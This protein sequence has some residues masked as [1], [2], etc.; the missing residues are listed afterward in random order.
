MSFNKESTLMGGTIITR[1]IVITHHNVLSFRVIYYHD[2]A[3]EH[4]LKNT[5]C[6]H[7]KM[8]E[9]WHQKIGPIHSCRMLAKFP[10]LNSFTAGTVFKRHIVR[11]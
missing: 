3:G 6:I 4:L 1:E 7:L 11:F 9:W 5:F 8:R 10:V 2:Y